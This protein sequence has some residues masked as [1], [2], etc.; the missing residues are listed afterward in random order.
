[1]NARIVILVAACVLAFPAIASEPGQSPASDSPTPPTSVQPE[2]AP[3]IRQSTSSDLIIKEWH[4]P[5][6]FDL[7]AGWLAT[8]PLKGTGKFKDIPSFYCDGATVENMTIT[9]TQPKPGTIRLQIDFDLY[10]KESAHDKIVETEFTLVNGDASLP[11]GRDEDKVAEGSTRST[12]VRYDR[13]EQRLAP[14]FA[15][16]T[17]LRVSMLVRND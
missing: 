16:G 17:Q 5:I 10:V 1:M 8:L 12:W 14:Y 13:S 9:K 6:T 4:S 11:L 2:A 3:Q 7:D 15:D